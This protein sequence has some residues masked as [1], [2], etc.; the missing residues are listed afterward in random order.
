MI[1]PVFVPWTRQNGQTLSGQGKT[2]D[3]NLRM[4]KDNEWIVVSDTLVDYHRACYA[5]G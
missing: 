2:V 1:W 4:E 5:I 3:Q